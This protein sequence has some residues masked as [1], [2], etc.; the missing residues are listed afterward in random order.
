MMLFPAVLMNFP[1]SKVCL[2]GE[3]S[4]SIKNKQLVLMVYLHCTAYRSTSINFACSYLIQQTLTSTKKIVELQLHCELWLK[5]V[6]LHKV[7]ILWCEV[8][9]GLHEE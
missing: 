8:K 9:L 4:I 3:W 6:K 7:H 1:N 5:L 2:I